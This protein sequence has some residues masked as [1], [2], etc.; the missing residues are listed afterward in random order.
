MGIKIKHRK[1]NEFHL[2]EVSG[3]VASEDA[4][5]ISRTIEGIKDKPGDK[6][7]VDLSGINYLDSHWMGVFVYSWKLL[8]ENNKELIF[9]IPPGFILDLFRNSNLDRTFRIVESLAL[10]TAPAPASQ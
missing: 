1:M 9:V 8:R 3:K 10:L 7:V 4:I 5:K 6:V 2:L